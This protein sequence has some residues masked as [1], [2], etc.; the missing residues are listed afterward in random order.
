MSRSAAGALTDAASA[1]VPRIL[2]GAGSR[3]FLHVVER[4]LYVYRRYWLVFL[5]GFFEPLMF[6]GSIG[7]G[8]GHLVQTVTG[9]GGTQISYAQ[10]VAPGLLAT[11]AMNGAIIDTT[12]GFFVN[13]KYGHIYDGMLATP[14]RIADVARGEVTWALMRG[15]VYSTVFLITMAAL[16]YV[17]SPWAVCALPVAVLMGLA[18]A[19]AGL[20]ATTWMRSFVDFDFVNLALV[21]MFLFSAVF[22]PLSRYPDVVGW[23]VRVT[24]LYQGVALERGLILGDVSWVMA[25]HAAYLVVMGLVGLRIAAARLG[26]LLQP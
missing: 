15:T 20:A 4:S 17:Q 25:G 13:F 23:L 8:V 12:F 3:R 14:M 16:G 6:L 1:Y 18:F 26:R 22:F 7:I 21:P 10:F 9:P 19:G 5:T 2:P 11:S 24:P